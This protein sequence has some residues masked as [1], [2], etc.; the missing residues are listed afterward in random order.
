MAALRRVVT[1]GDLTLR[2][3]GQGWWVG[4]LAMKMDCGHEHVLDNLKTVNVG[5]ET[6]EA[7]VRAAAVG[8]VRVCD[9]CPDA[10][11]PSLPAPPP[12]AAA[13]PPLEGVAKTG[14]RP[15]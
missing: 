15:L 5:L 8:S 9:E 2:G 12:A 4:R 11:P 1:V 3:G 13:P 7:A 10:S 14:R 6:F